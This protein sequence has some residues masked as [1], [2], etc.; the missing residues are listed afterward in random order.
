VMMAGCT[1]AVNLTAPSR[2]LCTAL[3]D[4]QYQELVT[5]LQGR[6]LQG[7]TKDQLLGQIPGECSPPAFFTTSADCEACVRA[8]VNEIYVQ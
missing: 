2:A 6:R 1:T 3:T 7:T 4:A 8:I 5:I